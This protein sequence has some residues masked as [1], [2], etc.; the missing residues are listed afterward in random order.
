MKGNIKLASVS[1]KYKT[2]KKKEYNIS[3]TVDVVL[4]A[5]EKKKVIKQQQT[6][7]RRVCKY[8]NLNYPKLNEPKI[9]TIK[10]LKDL[11]T[12]LYDI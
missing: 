8:L 6:V 4:V 11:G 1:I 9:N 12:T 5:N 7:I 2:G 10:I 3:R